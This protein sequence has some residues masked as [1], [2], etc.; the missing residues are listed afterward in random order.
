MDAEVAPQATEL[1]EELRRRVPAALALRYRILPLAWQEGTLVV[2]T[3]DPFNLPLLDELAVLLGCRVKGRE[4]PAAQLDGLVDRYYGA[5]AQ[6]VAGVLADLGGDEENGEAAEGG[7]ELAHQAPVVKLVNSV[8]AEALRKQASDVHLEPFEGT[9]RL[10]YRIDGV[11]HEVTPP[12]R[13]GATLPIRAAL[14]R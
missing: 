4:L 5:G 8:I 1:P 11:L 2:G 14:R 6:T 7:E 12:P 10:R 3:A 13:G 9:V